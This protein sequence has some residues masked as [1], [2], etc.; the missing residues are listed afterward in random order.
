LGVF[1]DADGHNA[2][3]GVRQSGDVAGEGSAVG[4]APPVER[5]LEVEVER[6]LCLG[7]DEA[8]GCSTL[9]QF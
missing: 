2:T 1:G 4:V 8:P 9:N 3:A 7:F 6:L 5:D